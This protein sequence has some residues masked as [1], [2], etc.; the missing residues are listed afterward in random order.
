M[1]PD[2]ITQN[3]ANTALPYPPSFIDRFIQFIQKLPVPYWLT[4]L[5][6]F[7]LQSVLNHIL[8]WAD[9]STPLFTFQR[10]T[11]TLPLWMWF[12]LAI[13]TFL[14]KASEAALDSFQPLLTID[15]V[16]ANKLKHEFTTMPGRGVVISGVAWLSVYILINYLFFDIYS[17][18][19][20]GKSLTLFT[21]LEGAIT[22][23]IGSVMYYHSIRLLWL[24][25]RTVKAAKHF[26]LFDLN[27]VYAFSRL[28][29]RI[30]VSWV[31]MAV[32]TLLVFPVEF[33]P[34]LVLTFAIIQIGLAFTAFVLPLRFVNYQLVLEK[35]RLLTE[36]QLRVEATLSLLHQHID[37][38]ELGKMEQLNNAITGLT[39]ER[40]IIEK[41][42]TWPW[43]TE[44]LTG[45]LSA[46]VIPILLLVIQIVIENWLTR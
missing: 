29:A 2:E 43:R 16:E 46:T 12:P 13:V 5:L 37:L 26:N 27:P 1:A 31:L 4:Y 28:T 42:P 34:E 23:A 39:A 25:N 3:H 11:L 18:I 21:V 35:R 22:F 8:V 10:V 41:V 45:F 32:F 14:N 15:D 38:N 20:W 44:T 33:K 9:K 30:G 36:N 7:I 40:G 17:S 24:V 6:L 19:G